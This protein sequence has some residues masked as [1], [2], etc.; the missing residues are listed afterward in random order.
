[1]STYNVCAI[2]SS[3]FN[4]VHFSQDRNTVHLTITVKYSAACV[5]YKLQVPVTSPSTHQ[6]LPVTHLHGGLSAWG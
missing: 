6:R 5:R 2:T 1:M 4:D 3:L